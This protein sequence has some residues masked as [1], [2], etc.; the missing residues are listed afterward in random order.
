MPNDIA[1]DIWVTDPPWSYRRPNDF[2]TILDTHG[3]LA[4]KRHFRAPDGSVKTDSYGRAARFHIWPL[5]VQDIRHLAELIDYNLAPLP[6][7][8]VVRGEWTLAPGVDYS[9][10]PRRVH[11]RR[12][13]DGTVEPATLKAA[14]HH[15]I[16]LDIDALHRPDHIDPAEDPDAAVEFAVEH[17]P[18]EFHG[19]TFFWQF[20]ASQGIKPGTLSLRLWFWS[21]RK[22]TDD[23]L[24]I[25]LADAPVD[26]SV[27]APAQPIYTAAPIFEGVPDPLG[28]RGRYGLWQGYTDVITPPAIEKPRATIAGWT[29][30]GA[31]ALD[32]NWAGGYDHYRS[33][34]GD[35]PGGT[36]FFNP[37]RSAV[38]A[39]FRQHGATADVAALRNDL[40]QAIRT[41][42]LDPAKGR[43]A[44]YVESRVRDLDSLILAIGERQAESEAATDEPIAPTY[45]LSAA[46]DI[47]AARLELDRIVDDFAAAAP[48]WGNLWP[49]ALGGGFDLNRRPPVVAINAPPGLGK[50]QNALNRV[51]PVALKAGKK[52][53]IGVP[54]HKLGEQLVT[55][56]AALE[57]RA[58]IYRSRDAKDPEAPGTM[59]CRE[60]ERTAAIMSALG[61]VNSL[62]CKSDQG[63]CEDYFICGYQRQQKDPPEV[64]LVAHECLFFD[65][66]SFIPRPD[67][68][69]IDERFDDAA[70]EKEVTLDI[71][72]L[73]HN[74]IDTRAF[75]PARKGEPNLENH[76]LIR[77]SE[78]AYKVLAQLRQSGR[79][80]RDL[81]SSITV[82]DIEQAHKSEWK[83][84]L[85]ID[86][87]APGT[88]AGIAIAR[89]RLR[90]E[91]NQEV[92]ALCKFWEYLAITLADK[93][94]LS[95][96]LRFSPNCPIP[97]TSKTL[98]GVVISSRREF[99]KELSDC[100][101][102]HLDGT[103]S[104][105]VVRQF[106]PGAYI[107]DIPVKQPTANVV[108]VRQETDRAMGKSSVVPSDSA[109]AK[110]NKTR[111]GH[112]EEIRLFIEHLGLTTRGRVVV[113]CQLEAEKLLAARD[114]PPNV[115]LAHLNAIT[116]LNDY[117]DAAALVVIGR[118]EP[119]PGSMEQLARLIFGREVEEVEG[120][121]PKTTRGLTIR[122]S[123]WGIPVLGSYH[124]DPAVEALRY[125]ATEGELLQAIH[126]GRLL[127]R[128]I[129]TPLR[130][131]IVTSVCLPI[132]V[133]QA[134]L[135]AAMRPTSIEIM[136]ARGAVSTNYAHTAVFY[137]DLFPNGAEAAKKAL[138]RE[139]L[140]WGQTPIDISYRSLSPVSE[141]RLEPE[142]L[143]DWLIGV[144]PPVFEHSVSVRRGARPGCN[145]L[146]RSRE[147]CRS[148]RASRRMA[149]VRGDACGR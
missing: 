18:S 146:L 127:N 130:I 70:I 48:T 124:P 140:N 114:L 119:A 139:R 115:V 10:A 59:M 87:V 110:T 63:I 37:L 41:A 4:T 84:K 148:V 88:P 9:N 21:D 79:L 122:A 126:R 54:R 50:T 6:R 27:F 129:S 123:E 34:I 106:F 51:V 64:W 118:T 104:V 113:I 8:F 112:L 120:Y 3:P 103:M 86:D 141:P 89:A 57:V 30:S 28:R 60:S 93:S 31:P 131:F 80:R 53:L 142:N 13:P 24:K 85:I 17:L 38:A 75:P 52:V 44:E 137:P 99:H 116:G 73:V 108:F 97:F 111:E 16:A 19:A 20:T 121:Y 125:A 95:L 133:D 117:A 143:R 109:S 100:P 58:R 74:R 72:L 92:R 2:L 128:T 76:E 91:H 49:R 98:P 101:I 78:A 29:P 43:S 132:E 90:E 35:H 94:D 69:I 55:T 96:Y 136:C 82:A 67:I 45:D 147:D 5:W 46:I 23:E 61:D 22:L 71:N 107:H 56:L 26:P 11:A 66:P 7:R 40:E 32:Y 68:V 39:F 83:R 47:G 138:K 33:C 36:G 102:L 134:M 77:I 65:L 1:S 105:P 81:F 15:W 42:V 12:S 25:W 149:S 144:C 62:A 145:S 135:W 14:S